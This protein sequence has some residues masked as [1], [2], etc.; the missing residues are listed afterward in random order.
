VS[1]FS[2]VAD[3]LVTLEAKIL[4]GGVAN[5]DD[6]I[7]CGCKGSTYLR[8]TIYDLRFIFIQRRIFSKFKPPD[9]RILPFVGLKS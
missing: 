7:H 3:Q 2:V 8:F 6:Q 4:A 9:R 5:V 1:L